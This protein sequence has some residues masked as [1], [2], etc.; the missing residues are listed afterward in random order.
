[1]KTHRFEMRANPDFLKLVDD[2][3][4]SQPG[5]PPR[6]EAIRRIVENALETGQA[7]SLSA[8]LRDWFAGDPARLS[9]FGLDGSTTVEEAVSALLNDRYQSPVI[10]AKLM[11]E[12]FKNEADPIAKQIVELLE[13]IAR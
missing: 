1:M 6:E 10:P 3:R 2:W 4:R 9:H 7:P 8:L 13:R 11:L 5:I 12:A